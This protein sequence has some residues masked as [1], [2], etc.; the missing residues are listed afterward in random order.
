M[1]TKQEVIKALYARCQASNDFVFDNNLVK[2]VC[3]ELSFGNPF[4]VTKIDNSSLLPEE[5]QQ[6]DAFIVHLGPPPGSR[7]AGISSCAGFPPDTTNSRLSRRLLR[8][9]GLT[10]AAS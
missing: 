2:D 8:C 9:L 5:L 10:A 6:E 1:G 7:T 3:R 4:D